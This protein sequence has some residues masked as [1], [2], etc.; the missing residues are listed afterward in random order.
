L[1]FTANEA[2]KAAQKAGTSKSFQSIKNFDLSLIGS[3]AYEATL[4]YGADG[5]KKA[6]QLRKYIDFNPS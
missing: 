3:N 5:L 6:R 2:L 1:L 4:E